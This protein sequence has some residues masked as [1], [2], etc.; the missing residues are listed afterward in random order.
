MADVYLPRCFTNGALPITSQRTGRSFNVI[1][2]SGWIIC[3]P[4]SAITHRLSDFAW[5]ILYQLELVR[6]TLQQE[7]SLQVVEQLQV[8]QELL[9][10]VSICIQ[11]KNCSLVEHRENVHTYNDE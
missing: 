8:E 1:S 3:R 6:L 5:C 9:E 11:G 10:D 4:I 7:Q 2:S